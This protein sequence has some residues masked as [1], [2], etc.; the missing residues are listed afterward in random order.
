M[1]KPAHVTSLPRRQFVQGAAALGAGA[2]LALPSRPA[3]A[4]VS[5]GNSGPP[6]LRGNRF[7]IRLDR[8]RINKSGTET[9]ANAINGIVPGPVTGA[10][11]RVGLR[12]RRADRDSV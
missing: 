12:F 11:P 1:S 5:G 8:I 7:D 2:A 10:K 9:W 4:A 3:A 6:V